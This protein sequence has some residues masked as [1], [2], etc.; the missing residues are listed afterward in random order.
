MKKIYRTSVKKNLKLIAAIAV[1]AL[2]GVSSAQAS[3]IEFNPSG[4]GFPSAIPA[5]P[6]IN[7]HGSGFV[8]MGPD[9]INPG[10][11]IFSETGAYQLTQADN[12]SPIGTRDIT[13]TYSIMG[14]VNPGT[15][16]LSFTG[17]SF[18]LYSDS[19]FNFGTASSNPSV[20]FGANDGI[21]IASFLISGG[22][23]QANGT[24]H[25][26]GN[27]IAGSITPGYFFS[28]TGEDLGL[29]GN[30][31]FS[32]DIGNNIVSPAANEISEII[33]KTSAFPI[34]G[35][36]EGNYANTPYYFAV[37]DGGTVNLSTTV[38][39]PGSMALA[40]AGLMGLGLSSRRTRKKQHQ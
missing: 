6:G 7:V 29:T 34:P 21:L 8:T 23:G 38:P 30:L 25:F 12:T 40:F 3:V 26:N 14:A 32:V 27:A 22:S 20:V 28:S 39:E 37:R 17:G 13:L 10:R 31:Q 18:N 33:C 9:Q 36:G 35:C 24:A 15:G 4:T 2:V 19:I 16:A 5:T 1:T 11:F